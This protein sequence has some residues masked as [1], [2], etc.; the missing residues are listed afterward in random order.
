M[1][2]H[3]TDVGEGPPAILLH[4]LFGTGT[5]FMTIQ[6]RLAVGRRV[7]AFDLRNHGR[8]AHDPVVNYAAMAE[9]VIETMHAHGLAQ[10]ALVGHSMGGK[11]AM[12]LALRDPARV[13]RL[14]I[15]DIAPAAYP[16]RYE[17]IAA[18]MLALP[19]GP[20]LTRAEADRALSQAVPE[21]SMRQFLLSNLRFG[22][23]PSWRI[24]LAE[25]AAGLP[26]IMGWEGRGRYD[27]PTLV[28]R[29]ER[30]DYVLPE[31]RA[32]FRALFP[33]ARFASLRDA[34]HWLHAEAPD[35]FIAT[36]DVFL[37]TDG[38]RVPPS[39]GTHA[40]P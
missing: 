20:E 23:S 17:A 2:L 19:L 27:G 39:D 6:R 37:E 18:A 31:H 5:N 4:G 34:G 3:A 25:I 21:A 8:S 13:A 36:V 29:G 15:A 33:A 7:L 22:A 12:T 28:L 9:D 14:L 26:A 1:I 11:V 30:S 16:P 10:A 35:A 38:R 40:L 32:L 24:G